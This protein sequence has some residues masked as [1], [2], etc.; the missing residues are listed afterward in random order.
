MFIFWEKFMGR[1]YDFGAEEETVSEEL[2]PLVAGFLTRRLNDISLLRDSLEKSDF[3][4]VQMIGHRLKGNSGG[5]G[6][7]AMGI[8][9]ANLEAAA[10]AQNQKESSELVSHLEAMVRR[11]QKNLS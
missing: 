3:D 8:L 6:F 9:G 7:P 1:G 5:F 11:L 2:L 4:T 10:K